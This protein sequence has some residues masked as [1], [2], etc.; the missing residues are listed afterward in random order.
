MIGESTMLGGDARRRHGIY[1]AEHVDGPPMLMS[2]TEA[3]VFWTR[4][5]FLATSLP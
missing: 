5:T 2:S 3:T 4:Y 1:V